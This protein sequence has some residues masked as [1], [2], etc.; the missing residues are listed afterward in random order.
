MLPLK[1]NLEKPLRKLN[2]PILIPMKKE[3][4]DAITDA[5]LAIIITLMVL[6]I[7]IPELTVENLPNILYQ[8]LI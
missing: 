7:K 1:G 8:I 4:L 2:N 3:R 5:I 6:E